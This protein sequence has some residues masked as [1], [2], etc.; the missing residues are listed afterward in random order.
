MNFLNI[1][2]KNKGFTLVETIFYVALFALLAITVTNALISMGKTFREVVV[3]KGILNGSVLMENLSRDI[4]QSFGVQSINTNGNNIIIKIYDVG[5][6]SEKTVEYRLVGNNLAFYQNST[7]VANLNHSSVKVKS[8][9]FSQIN[10]AESEAIGINIVLGH[11][12][13]SLNRDFNFQNT[14][15]LRDN[16]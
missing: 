6:S 8:L 5:T 2:N 7:F 10:T 9:T 11:N 14:I 12:S 15:V 16:Y 3:Y 1:K 13:D 4:R